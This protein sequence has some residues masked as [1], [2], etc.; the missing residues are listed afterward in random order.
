[1]Y[2][3]SKVSNNDMKLERKILHIN[4]ALITQPKREMIRE[5]EIF[6]TRSLYGSRLLGET[7]S[8]SR[9]HNATTYSKGTT[10]KYP[11]ESCNFTYYCFI[12]E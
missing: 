5:Q 1:M 3:F 9:K 2:Y 6:V 10:L 8:T 11:A 7:Y 12:Q 4:K